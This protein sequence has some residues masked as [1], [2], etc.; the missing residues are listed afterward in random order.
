MDIRN[1]SSRNNFLLQVNTERIN[2][3]KSQFVAA[4]SHDIRQPLQAISF[5]VNALRS[6]NTQP[7]DDALFERLENSVESMSDLLNNMLDVSKLDAQ[8]IV[9]QPKH[10]LLSKLFKK[11]QEELNP[12]TEDKSIQLIVNH[13]DELLFADT[14]LLEQVLNNL[15]S[16]AIRY[17]NSGSITLSAK[18]VSG[19]IQISVKD[20]GI[21][22]ANTDK[23]AIFLEFHQ[24][25]NPERDQNKGLG[26][27]LSI[28]KRLCALQSW[29]LELNSELGIGS[30]FSFTV[31]K[32]DRDKVQVAEKNSMNK[33]LAKLDVIVIDDHE[34]IC[35]SL[36]NTLESWGCNVRSFESAET[37]CEAIRKSNA[38]SPNLVISDYRLRKNTT[39]L[40]AIDKVTT[41]LGYPITAMIITGDTAPKEIT[42]IEKSGL[43]ILHK[44]IKPAQLRLVISKKMKA[45]IEAK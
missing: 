4:A 31:P 5:L 10:L 29:P 36:S 21:G 14:I 34:G 20:T 22:I 45:V 23:E 33:N 41:L 19:H 16:N 15:L 44:P 43:T 1:R 30:C 25:Y 24:I 32:G 2:S 9:P 39:G 26:L 13:S 38:W 18:S 3:E 8:S 12:F 40:E 37:A 42:K 27:G 28:V 17:T 11:L 7:K 35:F 6:G